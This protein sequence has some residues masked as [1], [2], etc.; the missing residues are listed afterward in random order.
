MNCPACQVAILGQPKRC[1][2]CDFPL[3]ELETAQLRLRLVVVALAFSPLLVAAVLPVFVHA[4][5]TP[6]HELAVL[7][8]LIWALAAAF[9]AV[10]VLWPDPPASMNSGAADH[11]AAL[12]GALAEG[13]ALL[14]MIMYYLGVDLVNLAGLLIVTLLLFALLATRLGKYGAAVQTHMLEEFRATHPDASERR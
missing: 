5:Q 8:Y 6:P 11:Q 9:G 2:S 12:Q 1:V 7:T 14:A 10:V 13:P 4:P 3:A